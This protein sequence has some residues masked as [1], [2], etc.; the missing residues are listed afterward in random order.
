[1][2]SLIKHI[3][4]RTYK[5]LLVR[6]LSKTRIYSWKGITV[7]VPPSVF[8][9]GFFTS[10]KLLLHY[11]KHKNFKKT[12]VLE[13]GAGSGLISIYAAKKGA[14]VMATDINPVAIRCLKRNSELNKTELTILHSDLFANIPVNH[15]ETIIIN[16]PYYKKE[17]T[18]NE[19]YGWY[20]GENGEYFQKLFSEIKNYMHE[21]TQVLMVL[22]DG[23]DL[24]MIENHAQEK[25]FILQCVYQKKSMIERNYIFQI[26]LKENLE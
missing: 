4:G 16:P 15:F 5:P 14:Y 9:P 11:I 3:L 1:M 19:E 8:H 24:E 7:E 20:C 13:L 18:T 10:T 2:R 17:P 6:Y 12:S 26:F 25:G 21:R 23:C 22:C